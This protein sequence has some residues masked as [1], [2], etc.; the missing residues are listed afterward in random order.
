MINFPSAFSMVD[1]N[2]TI[3]L[4][5]IKLQ[6]WMNR[7]LSSSLKGLIDRAESVLLLLQYLLLEAMKDLNAWHLHCARSLN[8]GDAAAAV[9][10]MYRSES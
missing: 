5:L 1:A 7:R 10:A 3:S 9:L 6:R 2:H 4:M 8:A